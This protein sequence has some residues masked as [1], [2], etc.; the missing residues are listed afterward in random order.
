MMTKTRYIVLTLA[1]LILESSGTTL[2]PSRTKAT[3]AP[4][5]STACA[6]PGAESGRLRGQTTTAAPKCTTNRPYKTLVPEKYYFTPDANGTMPCHANAT[7][8]VL[9]RNGDL[10]GVV[11]SLSQLEAKFNA[12]FGYPYVFLNEE[13]FSDEFRRA[14]LGLTSNK[15]EFRLIP[16]KH[17]HQ[18]DVPYRNICLFNSGLFF[19]H[20]LLDK[21]RYYWHVEPDVRFFCPLSYGPFLFMQDEGKKYGFP[22]SLPE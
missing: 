7:I 1:I 14:I 10:N 21:Y 6:S 2:S 19:R 3:A 12:R 16:K 9:A 22:V 18:P 11:K 13:P 17:W 15:V 20:P 5:P 8:V 4:R